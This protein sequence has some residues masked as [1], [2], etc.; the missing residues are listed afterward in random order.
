MDSLGAL[1]VFVQAAETR[2]FTATGRQLGV[3]SSAVGK[4]VARLEERLG[5]RLFH[6]STRAI[7]LTP[8][9]QMFLE[10][11][12]RIFSEMEAAELELSQTRAHPAGILRVSLPLVGMLMMPTVSA[13]L[14]AWPEIELDLDFSD[15]LVDVIEEG[16][17]AVIRTGE[18]S[19]SRLMTRRLGTFRFRLVGSPAYFGRHG[20]PETP[21]E[22]VRHR[23]LH[24]RY[25]T[26]GKLEEWL[27]VDENGTRIED[28]P[29]AAVSNAIEPLLH[30]AEQ[31]RGI[32]CLPDFAVRSLCRQ[33]RLVSVLDDAVKNTGA[34]RILWPSSRHLSPKLRVFVD[35]MA[36]T[37]FAER[38]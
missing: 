4:S 7:T 13:F 19:D 22:L 15:R 36:D 24:H 5:V 32:A 28:L 23:C 9:G 14:E 21:A 17:D 38:E 2:S 27:V 30:M 11:C 25:P 1:N 33:N 35:F 6:R 26:T 10:R 37:L 12:R 20:T 3:S 18:P 34:F 16:Y 8:E 29:R 31:G